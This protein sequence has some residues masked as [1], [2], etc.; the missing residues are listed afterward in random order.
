MFEIFKEFAQYG[1]LGLVIVFVGYGLW[2][3]VAWVGANVIKPVADRHLELVDKLTKTQ[4]EIVDLHSR[5]TAAIETLAS[6]CPG[7][8]AHQR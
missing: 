4:E 5:T 8:Q 2:R 1:L 6:S 7:M 3:M